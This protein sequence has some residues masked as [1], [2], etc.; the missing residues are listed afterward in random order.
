MPEVTGLLVASSLGSDVMIP[1]QRSIQKDP[2]ELIPLIGALVILPKQGCR[3]QSMPPPSRR[4]QFLVRIVFMCATDYRQ[5][6]ITSTRAV[7]RV[8][9]RERGCAGRRVLAGDRTSCR[10][11]GERSCRGAQSPDRRQQFRHRTSRT[12]MG[13]R[14]AWW[15]ARNTRVPAAAAGLA[16]RGGTQPVG[17]R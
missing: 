5:R 12:G 4:R 7:T 17:M 9:C 2:T 1:P 15:A 3:H 8:R 13:R 14:P 16:A 11:G 6:Q 10:S